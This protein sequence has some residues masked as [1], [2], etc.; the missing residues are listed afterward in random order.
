MIK[1]LTMLIAVAMPVSVLKAESIPNNWKR[2]GAEGQKPKIVN[3]MLELSGSG[4][5]IISYTPVAMN[6]HYKVSVEAASIGNNIKCTLL[7]RAS[8]NKRKVMVPLIVGENGKFLTTSALIRTNY[9]KGEMTVET[10]ITVVKSDASS[11]LIIKSISIENAKP[12]KAAAR[13]KK[14]KL[15]AND[16]VPKLKNLY[17]KTD[18]TEAVIVIG[19]DSRQQKLAK[20]IQ[21][22]IEQKS[23]KKIPIIK[24]KNAKI[25]YQTNIIA[26]GNRSSNKLIWHLYN[27]MY[28][29][30]DVKY[31]GKDGYV[32]RSLHN[33][34]SNGKNLIFLG[35]SNA[36]GTAQAVKYF[37]SLLKKT[38]VQDKRMIVDRLMKIKLPADIKLP[39]PL[40]YH[41]SAYFWSKVNKGSNGY[42]WNIIAYNMAMYYMTGI[43][44]YARTAVRLALQP[45]SKDKN[46]LVKY[47]TGSFDNHSKPL[48]HPYHYFAHNMMIFWDLIEESDVFSK[49]EKLAV[50]RGF[51]NQISSKNMNYA[52]REPNRAPYYLDRHGAI[53]TFAF[54][55]TARYFNKYYPN[56]CWTRSLNGVKKRFGYINKKDVYQRGESGN[57]VRSFSGWITPAVLYLTTSDNTNVVKDGRLSKMLTLYETLFDGY[58]SLIATS[59]SN[60]I[61]KKIANLTGDGKWLYYAEQTPLKPKGVFR[62]G[63]SFAPAP[64]F[65]AVPPKDILDKFIGAKLPLQ[66][67]KHYNYKDLKAPYDD[68]YVSIGYRNANGK[69]GD[70]LAFDSLR[71]ITQTPYNMNSILALRINGSTI[72]RGYGNYVQVSHNGTF[73]KTIPQL[74]RVKDFGV[75]KDTAYIK[76][77]VPEMSWDRNVIIK[78]FRYALIIDKITALQ[79][80]NLSFIQNWQGPE[81]TKFK[82]K[83]NK[84]F[85]QT[86]NTIELEKKSVYPKNL[87]ININSGKVRIKSS[88]SG[89]YAELSFFATEAICCELMLELKTWSYGAEKFKVELDGK[90]L[91]NSICN[92]S[93][94]D[95][96]ITISLGKINIKAGK[97]ILKFTVE[98]KSKRAK[99]A[100]IA[101][102]KIFF[103]KNMQAFICS[104]GAK[105][106]VLSETNAYHRSSIKLKKNKSYSTFTLLGIG[107]NL[108]SK[109]LASNAAL[110]FTPDKALAFSGKFGNFGSAYIMLIDEKSVFAMGVTQIAD[111]F[112]SEMPL[113][114]SWN[115][116]TGLL[117]M[118]CKETTKVQAGGKT[119]T[120]KTGKNIFLN[121]FAPS[122]AVKKLS[123]ALTDLDNGH[124]AQEQFDKTSKKLKSYYK[125]RI[126]GIFKRNKI[127]EWSTYLPEIINIEW[128]NRQALAVVTNKRLYILSP[129]GELI[130]I[131]D[132]GVEFSKVYY[133]KSAGLLLIGRADR[134]VTAFNQKDGKKQWTFQSKA[135]DSIQKKYGTW[136]RTYKSIWSLSSGRFPADMELAFIGS[137]SG[138]ELLDSN[139]KLIK[140]YAVKYGA[141]RKMIVVTKP[142][143]DKQLLILCSN[144]AYYAAKVWAIDGKT[145]KGINQAS[146]GFTQFVPAYSKNLNISTSGSIRTVLFYEDFDGDGKKDIM[147]DLQRYY[148]LFSLY[149]VE[150][151]TYKPIF[152]VNLGPG[153]GAGICDMPPPASIVCADI[154]GTK[155][156]ELIYR[157]K[158]GNFAA[159]NGKCNPLWSKNLSFIPEY[160]C[161]IAKGKNKKLG[162]VFAAGGKKLALLDGSGKLVAQSKL[163]SSISVMHVMPQSKSVLVLL[164][165]G[166]LLFFKVPN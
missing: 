13:H 62:I 79:D 92:W 96:Y 37:I 159:I 110:L 124:F 114:V 17:L 6:S 45:N 59:S 144:A 122:D 81:T 69:S 163:K 48:S 15:K 31:P 117:E 164:K 151:L 9:G 129:K 83:S 5:G 116:K 119:L 88:K 34:F 104:S 140:R 153:S 103:K 1:L 14:V 157:D 73:S 135:D 101:L 63:Q 74:G 35:G 126:P 142:N 111:I 2:L 49:A 55:C 107:E 30:L 152:Q 147:I 125:T 85:S 42:G 47:D 72:L 113:N 38:P 108:D 82:A 155:S 162:F 70:Y 84:V 25:P 100:W 132:L 46:D 51:A 106:G 87:D 143:K 33:T 127:K 26:L 36:N 11:K 80:G 141:V 128:K 149:S 16:L 95:E 154:I 118:N 61:L 19:P 52:Y 146:L 53:A 76:T 156:P 20:D 121:I 89:D 75:F 64:D 98:Q 10:Q 134:K 18:L 39:A 50:I 150:N 67:L 120:L 58:E 27:R 158:Y 139:G 160:L 54:F 3:N 28:T 24:D 91:K 23:G 99:N 66:I 40:D 123:K 86:S 65:K 71:E 8:Y 12:P 161:A 112:S 166:Q 43:K 130:K 44:K 105:A 94:K 90:L 102:Q 148:K 21:C 7:L 60:N 77:N 131:I 133:W 41:K 97:H 136:A 109:P 165:T 32:V 56:K 57:L 68:C 22:I 138:V 137:S 115:L 93:K 29:L 4:C 145:G 78:K